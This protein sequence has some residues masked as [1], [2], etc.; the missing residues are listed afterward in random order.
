MRCTGAFQKI[1][2][3]V[4]FGCLIR[5]KNLGDTTMSWF[6]EDRKTSYVRQFCNSVLRA[7]PMPKHVAIIMDGN[8][9][10]AEKVHCAR[11]KGHEKGFDKLTEVRALLLTKVLGHYSL[12]SGEKI[13][14]FFL[15]FLL[16]RF[17]VSALSRVICESST[18]HLLHC[19][20]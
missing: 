2:K 5:Q 7:G 14:D 18:S 1:G 10:F 4:E 12:R 16:A 17:L 9:R 3:E 19:R 20:I 13:S 11:L 15:S 6:K 8:R